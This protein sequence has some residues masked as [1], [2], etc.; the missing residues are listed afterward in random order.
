MIRAILLLLVL[1][2][3]AVAGLTQQQL[4]R[5]RVD[6]P[7]DAAVNFAPGLPT[8][9]ILADFDCS[10][11]CDAVLAQ[12]AGLLAEVGL[13][14]GEDYAL[15]VVG[16]DP[17]DDSATAQDF[18]ARQ[19]PTGMRPAIRVM[20]PDGP[21]LERMTAAL[22]YGYAHDAETGQFAHPAARF[23]LRADGGVSAVLPAFDAAP[24]A[25][26]RAILGAR[27]GTGAIATQLIVLCYGFDPVTGR[28]SLAIWRVLSL[29]SGLTLLILGAGLGLAFWRERRAT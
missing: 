29:L 17:R 23:V 24:D 14:P 2:G 9:L 11:V 4:D 25:L 7:E 26:R 22:G 1:A 13:A 6:L 16:L 21:A 28:Y 12:T 10:H 15:I 27:F 19:T 18:I 5:V 3:P 20:Q 8:V